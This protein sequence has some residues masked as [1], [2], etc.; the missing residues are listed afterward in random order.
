MTMHVETQQDPAFSTLVTGIV[1][2]AKRLLV[3]QLTL[4]KV[5]L[6][7]DLHR[8]IYALIPLAL[9]AV[10]VLTAL[11]LLG[12]GAAQGL[13]AAIPTLPPWSGY[14]IVGGVVALVGVLL[15]IWGVSI[16]AALKPADTALKGLEENLQWK[17]KN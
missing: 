3:N 8:A 10:V 12:I 14:V 13:C 2:D 4:F 9:G 7:N 17:M 15:A 6:S 16:L 5:E 11:I 1:E